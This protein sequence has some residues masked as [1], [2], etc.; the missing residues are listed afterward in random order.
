MPTTATRMNV[1][2]TIA[3]A[4]AAIAAARASGARIGFVPTMGALH[5][6]HLS[7][8]RRAHEESDLVVM[9]IFVNPLQFGPAED[10]TR[11]PRP[12]ED[13]EAMASAEGVDLLF[14]PGVEEM[15]PTG[16]SVGVTAGALATSWEGKSRPGHF[17]G[18]A[19][20]VAKLLNIVQ[21]DVAIFGRKDL[22]QAAIIE[23]MVRDLDMPV[24]IVVAPIVR[25]ADGLALSSR[26]R[27]LSPEDRSRAIA[28]S[29]ALMTVRLLFDSGE[30]RVS[31]LEAAGIRIL[32]ADPAVKPDYLAV[33]D[34][35]TFEKPEMAS[36]GNAAIVAARVGT[37]RLIDNM[38]LGLDDQN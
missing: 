36:A 35:S 1:V 14:R 11:Y 16:R 29:R 17:D 2:S 30:H 18:V 38:I 12:V 31:L 20:V 33:V 34:P 28:L 10:F 5:E 6:G 15:Y 24:R 23:A 19:T 22:Q 4:R 25:E 3:D 26:N 27:Y 13:D 21:P 37:T 32:S 9:S 8:V 7:L